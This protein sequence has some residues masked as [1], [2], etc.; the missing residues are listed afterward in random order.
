M[1]TN[2]QVELILKVKR[3]GSPYDLFAKNVERQGWCSVRQECALANMIDKHD[4]RQRQWS[5]KPSRQHYNDPTD[6]GTNGN[7]NLLGPCVEGM[8]GEFI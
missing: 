6:Y 4:F 5:Y 7:L 1:F 2:K 3:L 8:P